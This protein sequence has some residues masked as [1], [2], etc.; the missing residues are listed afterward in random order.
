M[1]ALLS[2]LHPFN[3]SIIDICVLVA[4][5]VL[6]RCIF[7]ASL[8]RDMDSST[9]QINLFTAQGAILM[10][11]GLILY[12][13]HHT[14]YLLAF[15]TAFVLV[16]LVLLVFNEKK[17]GQLY[18]SD[19][20]SRPIRPPNWPSERQSVPT[21]HGYMSST[22]HYSG[23]TRVNTPI[24][25][26]RPFPSD[27]A[28]HESM[29][30]SHHKRVGDNPKLFVG[31]KS[32][33][34]Q[35]LQR[36]PLSPAPMAGGMSPSIPSGRVA[37]ELVSSHSQAVT[38]SS[39]TGQTRSFFGQNFSYLSSLFTRK[40]TNATPSGMYNLGNTCF[41][42]STLQCLIWT[43]GFI[44]SLPYMYMSQVN[45]ENAKLVRV[46]DD[47]V[48]Y[49]HAFSDGGDNF[50]PVDITELLRSISFVAPHL[51]AMPDTSAYQSQQD[52]AEFLLWLLNH[53]HGVLRLQS[54]G[55]SGLESVLSDA[56]ISNLRNSKKVCM[57]TLQQSK[58]TDIPRLREPLTNLSLVDWQ[59]HWQEDCSSLYQL[60]LGQLIEARECQRCGKMSF[61]IEYFT[62]LPLPLPDIVD[63][64]EQSYKLEDCFQSFSRTEDMTQA[65]M[66]TCS[67]LDGA[68][69][70]L[71]PG[72]RLTLLSK[73]PKRLVI[74]LTRY[75]YD[76]VQGAAVKNTVAVKFSTFF[77]LFP[78]TMSSVLN[79]GNDSSDQSMD[80]EL[81]GFC[82]HS[83]AQSTSFGHY[84]AYCKASNG[85]WYYFNDDRVTFI[86]NIETELTTT[87]VLQNS[88]LLFYSLVP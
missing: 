80:Y 10:L 47:V 44:D 23:P 63:S 57:S 3:N 37:T 40:N 50:E 68:Q 83:G 67:C 84:V 86:E 21:D 45:N 70:T 56:N 27:T 2:R 16:R 19:Y 46:L 88:Y 43:N 8:A 28:A 24:A 22:T 20:V 41:I 26:N 54:S 38:T 64:D 34:G 18:H 58:S 9:K 61:N 66:I 65:N 11:S 72:R 76:S 14:P 6:T 29:S 25:Q 33:P 1:V 35:S 87:F 39:S 49:C 5:E 48:N 85:K 4:T 59:L 75:S 82:V 53:L 78:H 32:K 51:V 13:F 62:M 12:I 79:V 36:P 30:R 71:T 81:Q 73:P 15:I 74:Q 52:A 17:S 77:N 55:K 7:S 42:N 31:G 69:D 60:F